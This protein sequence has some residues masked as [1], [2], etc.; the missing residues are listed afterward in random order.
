MVR[1]AGSDIFKNLYCAVHEG[2][3]VEELRVPPRL[4]TLRAVESFVKY[5]YYFF[6]TRR[7]LT[8]TPENIS[9]SKTV[10]QT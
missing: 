2:F 4:C 6:C 9:E 7:P 3:A 8:E 10:F 5:F 1:R